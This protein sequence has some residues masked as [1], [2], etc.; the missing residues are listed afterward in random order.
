MNQIKPVANATPP[1]KE[2]R[3][4]R[5]IRHAV[6]ALVRGD[7][8]TQ[9]Q[10]AEQAGLSRETLCRALKEAHVRAYLERRVKETIATSQAPA[11]AT[12]LDL[13]QNA[14]SEHVTKDIAIHLLKLNGHVPPD[15]G[16]VIG[17]GIDIKAGFVIDLREPEDKLRV[18][19]SDVG[20]GDAQ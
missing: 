3:V 12:L 10:A 8:K 6:E 4:T 9:K 13:L 11:V 19:G 20:A 17:I 15:D 5:R 2:R 1:T 7:A 14:T 16:R 18:V